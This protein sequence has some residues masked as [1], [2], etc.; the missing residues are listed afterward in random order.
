MRARFFCF[1]TLAVVTLS[2]LI[3][4]CQKGNTGPAGPAG[5]TGATG[6]TGAAG[7][8]GT[9]N[10]I[11]SAWFT[12]SPWV[13][14]T[15]Y[16]LYGFSYTKATTDISQG[17]VDSGTVITFGKLTGYITAIWPATQI[18]QLPIVVSYKF[19]PT[20]I[21]YNDTWSALVTAGNLKIQFVDDQNIY[22]SISNAHQFRY[23]I[24]PGGTKSVAAFKQGAITSS[25]K[26]ISA[27]DL[28]EVVQ[29][30]QQMSYA[31]VCQRLGIEP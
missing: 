1:K 18:A 27:A 21:T 5:P 17:I 15:V 19:S 26:R 4:S 23:I 20:G 7:P 8:A 31:E 25:G 13:K 6:S 12:P 14:D 29:N 16:N 10:V 30:Y 11:Y 3:I 22:G 9:A 28:N 2:L 24:I